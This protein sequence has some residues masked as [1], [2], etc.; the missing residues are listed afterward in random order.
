MLTERQKDALNFIRDYIKEHDKAPLIDEIVAGLSITS[1]STAQRYVQAL[2]EQGYLKRYPTRKR[3][4][5]LIES[6]DEETYTLP[7]LGKIAAG[8]LIEAIPDESS[9]D[10]GRL[11][12]GNG[13]YVLKVSGESMIEKGILSGDYVVMDSRQTPQHKDVA[14]ALVDGYDATLKT[15]LFNADKTITLMPANPAFEPITLESS[16]VSFQGVMV[17]Q[18]RVC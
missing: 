15:I 1:R 17:G 12:F 5:E 11:F 16:R 2:V 6:E 14:V 13:R 18:F 7:L 8:R 3:G 9:I 4:L 10:V